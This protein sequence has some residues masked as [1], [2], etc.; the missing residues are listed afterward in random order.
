MREL[1]LAA[2]AALA[3]VGCATT[4]DHQPERAG[5]APPVYRLSQIEGKSPAELDSILGP[6]DLSRS[7]GV[8]E[9]RRYR[10][11]LCSLIV[12]LYPDDSGVK[13]ATNISAGSLRSGDEKPNLDACLAAGKGSAG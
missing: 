13:R 9:F 1:G 6:A 4:I 7:E 2:S 10:M 5:D 8:G 12:V 11:R 3:A